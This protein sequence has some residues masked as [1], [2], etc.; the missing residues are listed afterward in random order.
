MPT[1]SASSAD[2]VAWKPDVE[3][4][5]GFVQTILRFEPDYDGDVTA[6]LVRN[7]PLVNGAAGAVLYLHGFIDYFFQRHV[8]DEFTRRRYNYYALDLR[9]YGRSLSTIHPNFCKQISEYFPEISSA[10]EIILGEGSN[11]I[12]LKAHSTGAL[13]ALLY[14]KEGSHG[15]RV[16]RIILNS[17]F[18]DF[19]EPAAQTRL[20]AWIGGFLPFAKKGNPV[21]RWYGKSLHV[22]GKGEWTFNTAL[23][24]LDGFPAYY[25]WVRAVVEAHD[26][27]R[28]G[29]HL[30]QPVLVLHSDRS[31]D[32]STWKEEFH[33]ADLIL[34][35][36]DI[37][38]LSSR[39]GPRVD[40]REIAGAK[41]DVMLS[42]ADV[43]PNAVV[44]IFD[45][46]R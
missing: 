27:V 2:V 1:S 22:S 36:E 13:P 8:A 9:K 28:A 44:A 32:G 11:Q 3:L 24:P 46:L 38:S 33:R 16:S 45:W 14:A 41:H 18:L 35:V 43:L 25:G 37:K 20:A 6:T 12:V 42:Q 21:N 29:L 10:I 4:G 31:L 15:D 23:K 34:D 17:P 7:D 19:K 40:R 30:S 26:R 5:A 39:L